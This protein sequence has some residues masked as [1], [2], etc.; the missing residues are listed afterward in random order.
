MTLKSN[1][2]AKRVKRALGTERLQG[3]VSKPFSSSTSSA[4][5]VRLMGL[6]IFSHTKNETEGKGVYAYF[7]W[8]GGWYHFRTERPETEARAVRPN[9]MLKALLTESIA[10]Y[11]EP[12]I[13]ESKRH[14]LLLTFGG[15]MIVWN[16]S[17]TVRASERLRDSLE[18]LPHQQKGAVPATDDKTRRDRSTRAHGRRGHEC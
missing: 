5:P 9:A 1:V 16:P 2:L 10:G 6:S 13:L 17:Q 3:D 15:A 18:D 8:S 4:T 7:I 11:T 12:D 14:E